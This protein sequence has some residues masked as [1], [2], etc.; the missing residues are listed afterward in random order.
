MRKP[1]NKI[2][3]RKGEKIWEIFLIKA[4][5]VRNPCRERE[6]IGCVKD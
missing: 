4:L 2:K 5:T 6:N 1:S 3:E